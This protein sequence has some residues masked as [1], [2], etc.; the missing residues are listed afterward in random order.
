MLEAGGRRPDEV[1]GV[2]T[3]RRRTITV[4]KVA[5][6][7]VMA[8]CR[9]EYFPVVLASVEAMLEDAFGLHLA[10]ASTGSPAVLAL[11]NGPIRRALD[12]NCGR[13][14]LSPGW[15]ANATIGRAIRLVLMNLC[16]AAPADFDGGTMGNPAKYS[17]CLGE[18]EEASPWEPL[19]AGRG[20]PA[21]ASAVT[22]FVA[23]APRQ[24]NNRL[25]RDPEIILGT[26]VDMM[27]VVGN[28][29]SHPD[30]GGFLVVMS[31]EH[32]RTIG[33]AGWS[34]ADVRR[35]LWERA[36]R[37]LADFKRLARVPGPIEP[38]DETRRLR[39]MRH[40]EDVFVAVAGSPAGQ[41]SLVIPIQ[42]H[43]TVITKRVETR[44]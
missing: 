9:P 19:A 32:A 27:T 26:V 4:E 12:V 1:L 22:L 15:R 13:N 21:G 40:P 29:T 25:A 37:P 28:A 20:V 2:L 7:A 43:G 14:A 33:R 5:I 38:G 35:F 31:P 30:E 17:Y 39:M 11:I 23:E 18:D 8:G 34:R 16:G 10:A 41:Y 44:G 24:L 36:E 3:F 42:C 6:N